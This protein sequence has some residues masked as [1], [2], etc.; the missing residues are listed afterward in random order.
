MGLQ[1]GLTAELNLTSMAKELLLRLTLVI[2]SA[3]LIPSLP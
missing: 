3:G 1:L 2:S